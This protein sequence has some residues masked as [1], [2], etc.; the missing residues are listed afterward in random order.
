MEKGGVIDLQFAPKHT[1]EHNI[2]QILTIG[3]RGTKS[4]LN[5]PTILDRAKS[6]GENPLR[7]RLETLSFQVTLTS[8]THVACCKAGPLS[9]RLEIINAGWSLAVFRGHAFEKN[10][11]M[12]MSLIVPKERSPNGLR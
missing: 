1:Q 12:Q 5:L 10:F 6:N 3:K 2:Q 11:V 4:V 7:F 9:F 8:S